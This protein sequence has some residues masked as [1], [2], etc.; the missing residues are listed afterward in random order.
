VGRF[1][2]DQRGRSLWVG[3]VVSLILTPIVGWI[4]GVVA[5]SVREVVMDADLKS[6][7]EELQETY[8]EVEKNLHA[9]S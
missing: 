4:L 3:F 2:R 8:R 1:W 6:L 9:H 5:D 7:R